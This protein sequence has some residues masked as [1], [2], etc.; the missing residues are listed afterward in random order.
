MLKL[1]W[2]KVDGEWQTSYKGFVIRSA[3]P[4]KWTA[5]YR[6]KKAYFKLLNPA[7][8]SPIMTYDTDF[9]ALIVFIEKYTG[10]RPNV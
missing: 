2:R 8:N 5:T 7:L 9:Y 3:K 6:S 4:Q 1:N 10:K